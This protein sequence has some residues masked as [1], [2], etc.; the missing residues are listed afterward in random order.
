MPVF[1]MAS[2]SHILAQGSSTPEDQV[3]W[4]PPKLIL[5]TDL[6]SLI[7]FYPTVQIGVEYRITDKVYI[8]NSLGYVFGYW[9]ERDDA[10]D[11]GDGI[12]NVDDI[13]NPEG[14]K[15][16]GEVKYYFTPFTKSNKFSMYVAPEFVFR[17]IASDG[18][19]IKGF[20]CDNNFF[21]SPC[22]YFQYF[23]YKIRQYQYFV[24]L[25]GGFQSY[26]GKHWMVD[27]F[28]LMGL[29]QKGVENIGKPDAALGDLT[30]SETVVVEE[31]MPHVGIGFKIG[32]ILK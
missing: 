23:P 29:K 9:W 18:A 15:F 24:N 30:L 32:Y 10:E 31:F 3:P 12:F 26:H 8:E 4:E 19:E 25:K 14:V 6:L 11:F 27:F 5:K 20:Q 22:G 2:F 16:R 17:Y 13:M 21:G 28:W 1:V 7:D